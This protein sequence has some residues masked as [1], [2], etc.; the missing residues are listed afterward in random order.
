MDSFVKTD[1]SSAVTK[2]LHDTEH[3]LLL[4]TVSI[5]ISYHYFAKH[6]HSASSFHSRAPIS[7]LSGIP[8]LSHSQI[9][10][11][12]NAVIP[13]EKWERVIDNHSL[14]DTPGS[15]CGAFKRLL[16]VT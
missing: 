9:P 6:R 3:K 14:N 12:E 11:N 10:G 2:E 16:L 5:S 7:R 15:D 1:R 4:S 13:G 8:G